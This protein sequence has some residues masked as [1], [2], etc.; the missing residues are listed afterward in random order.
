MNGGAGSQ[1]GYC[2]DLFW[3]LPFSISGAS[4]IRRVYLGVD[5]GLL[6]QNA[7]QKLASTNVIDFPCCSRFKPHKLSLPAF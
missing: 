5:L 2:N 7:V 6:T 3:S 4:N 1:A